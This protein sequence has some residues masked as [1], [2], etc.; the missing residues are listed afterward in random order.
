VKYE[1][2]RYA[3]I[4][5]Q[6]LEVLPLPTVHTIELFGFV[7][8]Y[9]IDPLFYDRPYCLA[10]GDGGEKAYAPLRHALMETARVG[11]G[12]LAVRTRE[13]LV[14]VQPR[15]PALV[16]HTLRDGD[17]VRRAQDVPDLPKTVRRHVHEHR[18][19]ARLIESM[20]VQFHPIGMRSEYKEALADLVRAKAAG[21]RPAPVPP[22]RPITDLDEAL[23]ESLHRLE[24]ERRARRARAAG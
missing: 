10:P 4:A 18:M 13:H 3:P 1:A 11:L 5:E 20:A 14:A 6:G 23:R 21:R 9:E 17:E 24:T 2:D 16:A 22:V 12:R 15:G 8:R 19:A 7:G